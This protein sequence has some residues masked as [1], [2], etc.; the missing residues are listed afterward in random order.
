MIG[1]T[2]E[3]VVIAILA[4]IWLAERLGVPE[5]RWQFYGL[6]SILLVILTYSIYTLSQVRRNIERYL[7][8]GSPF[9][10]SHIQD[11]VAKIEKALQGR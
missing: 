8:R 9:Y 2:L 6:L 5:P 10:R 3:L 1:F 4:I 11:E 7:E